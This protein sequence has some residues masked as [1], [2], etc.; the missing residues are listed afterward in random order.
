MS[1]HSPFS[2][3]TEEAVLIEVVSKKRKRCDS[4]ANIEVVI[5]TQT[6]KSNLQCNKKLPAFFHFP[7]SALFTFISM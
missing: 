5:V 7:L 6:L 2:S 3:N 4:Q 1:R